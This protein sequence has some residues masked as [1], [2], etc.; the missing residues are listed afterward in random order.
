MKNKKKYFLIY[1]AIF[2]AMALA[3]FY[4]Y[5]SRGLSF[6]YDGDGYSQHYKALIYYSDY[7][8]EIF[9]NIFVNHDFS[10]Q[11]FDFAIGEGRDIL[12][13]FHYYVIGDPIAFLSVFVPRAYLYIFYD[14]SIILR[15]YLSGIAFFWLASYKKER[16]TISLLAGSITYVFCFWMIFNSVRHIYFLNPMIYLPLVILGVEKIINQEN[17]YLLT[18]AVLVSGLSNFYFFFD[19]VLLTII[20]VAV[21]LLILYHRDVRKMVK[22]VF[23]IFKYSLF[24]ALLAGVILLP[25]IGTFL[26]DSRTGL[27]YGRHLLY[28]LTYY[29]KLPSMFISTSRV[30]WLCMGYASPVI[31]AIVALLLDFKK[32]PLLVVLLL[33]G[34]LF[35]IFPFFGQVFNGLSYMSNKWC[36]GFSL[37]IAYI[38][39][40]MWD[41][42][43][44]HRLVEIIVFVLVFIGCLII[45]PG[46]NML[47]PLALGLLFCILLFIKGNSGVV[48]LGMFALVAVNI[49]FLANWEYA[50]FGTDYSH[51]ATTYKEVSSIMET[52]ESY[53]FSNHYQDDDF[54][55][56]SGSELTQNASI[57]FGTHTTDFYWSLN[58]AN[59]AQFRRDMAIDEYSLFNYRE[60]DKRSTLYKLAN[61]KYY[62][63]PKGYDGLIPSGYEYEKSIDDY[64]VYVANDPL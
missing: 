25:I 12:E 52:S 59:E 50:P 56:I 2:I 61:V 33:L 51:T 17:P 10:I 15:L 58:N 19:I 22:T 45:S 35:I 49:I 41:D 31:L 21:R 29:L 28:P 18:I 24:G 38:L 34:A 53:S 6:I 16:S 54:Y 1:T 57:L 23:I 36:F 30:Y 9:H 55:R 26:S 4:V 60:F 20:Y 63:T 32:K 27:D 44:K 14:L 43:G 7:L 13:N 48:Q 62:L 40:E 42:L 11:R 46:I 64:D 47:I 37:L 8:K 39:T 5:Y 3:C